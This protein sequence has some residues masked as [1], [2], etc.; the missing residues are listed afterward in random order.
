MARID[1][2]AAAAAVGNGIAADRKSSFFGN[3]RAGT[4][5]IQAVQT[6]SVDLPLKALVWH[7]GGAT[8]FAADNRVTLGQCPELGEGGLVRSRDSRWAQKRCIS[9]PVSCLR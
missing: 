6:I 5:L 9:S 8:R 4:P 7:T 1:Y 3:A 2:A